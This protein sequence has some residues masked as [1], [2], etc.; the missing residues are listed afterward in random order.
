MKFKVMIAI[1]ALALIAGAAALTLSIVPSRGSGDGGGNVD[2]TFTKWLT[3]HDASSYPVDMSG[4]V[5]GDVGAGSFFG[6]VLYQAADQRGTTFVHALYHFNGAKHS[7]TADLRITE[8]VV[9][10]VID[11]VQTDGT[12]VITG[13]VTDGW[14]KGARVEGGEYT[15]MHVCP[16]PT[17]GNV[18]GTRCYV[19]TL[20]IMAG[21]GD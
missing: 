14:R 12:G 4:V 2:A 18:Q 13:V 5:G 21:S 6:E 1:F 7:F 15:V 19:G 9:T 20:H 11:G 8:T 3:D 16:I 10:A 17:P